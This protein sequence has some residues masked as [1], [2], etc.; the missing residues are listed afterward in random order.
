MI[1]IANAPCSW[2][3]LEFDLENKSE[4]VPFDR[5]LDELMDTGYLGTE[6]GD[7]GYM[8]T[9]PQSLR[10]EITIRGLQLLGA[11]VPVALA[12]RANHHK[13][14]EAALRVAEL[15]YNAGFGE[16]FIILADENASDPKRTLNAGRI[17][18][19][20]GLGPRSM[21]HFCARG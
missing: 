15:M 8:P 10:S 4:E 13:G 14:K 5:V 1:K 21:E 20:N 3:A 11:F 6:L 2:G 18:P 9:N 16:A 19:P 7:W 12:D 17:S